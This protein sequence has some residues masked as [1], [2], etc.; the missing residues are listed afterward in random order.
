M[1][2][3]DWSSDVC[4]SDLSCHTHED[5]DRLE[6]YQAV[7]IKL[8]KAGGLTEAMRL[9]E[10]ARERGLDVMIGC[11]LGTSLG[12]APAFLLGQQAKWV[13]LDGALLLEKDRKGALKQK[14]G[15]LQPGT[16]WGMGA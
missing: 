5:L 3:S 4:S 15:L 10:K 16:L 11:M 9:A 13:D 14:A 1:R 12:I 2:I 6:G 8:D 7:N